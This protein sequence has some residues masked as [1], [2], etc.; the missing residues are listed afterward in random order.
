MDRICGALEAQHSLVMPAPA[1]SSQPEMLPSHLTYHLDILRSS[2][3][4]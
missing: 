2:S 3:P 1:L 4:W